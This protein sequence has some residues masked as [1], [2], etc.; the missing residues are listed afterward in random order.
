MSAARPDDSSPCRPSPRRRRPRGSQRSQTRHP[1]RRGRPER[2]THTSRSRRRPSLAAPAPGAR[3]PP[4]PV[5]PTSTSAWSPSA[6]SKKCQRANG[7]IK[8]ADTDAPLAH[9][10]RPWGRD[11]G[12]TDERSSYWLVDPICGTRNFASG[13]P[14]YCVNV[15]PVENGE[16]MVAVVSRPTR[17]MTAR[18]AAQK[19]PWK[20]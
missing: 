15:A 11:R 16:V 20:P 19:A 8:G 14:L 17:S 10:R 6:S 1:L 5:E 13:I 2:A 3:P 9:D 7:A 18:G 4:S 12:S